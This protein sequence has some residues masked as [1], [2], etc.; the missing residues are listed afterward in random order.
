MHVHGWIWLFGCLA[1]VLNIFHLMFSL[2][3]WNRYC[4]QFYNGFLSL[5][6]VNMESLSSIAH[7]LAF[8]FVISNYAEEMATNTRKNHTL[9]LMPF[10]PQ[11]RIFRQFPLKFS[12][13]R[14]FITFFRPCCK[15]M[16]E[17]L[18]KFRYMKWIFFVQQNIYSI[19]W[20]ISF[21][22]FFLLSMSL[23]T[24]FWSASLL[25]ITMSRNFLAMIKKNTFFDL[26][27]LSWPVIIVQLEKFSVSGS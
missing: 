2:A 11:V 15:L 7:L 8:E 9:N 22:G 18:F 3:E 12:Q 20:F 4:Y 10:S 25:G 24:M 23:M 14:F 13:I 27:S 21:R 19:Q 17:D 6:I 1:R 5:C 16:I 26:F